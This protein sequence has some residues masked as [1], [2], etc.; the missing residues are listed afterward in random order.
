[1]L[2][3]L[4]L[5]D[6]YGTR[7]VR[8]GRGRHRRRASACCS[9]CRSSAS[10]TTA[11]T[12]RSRARRC[13]SSGCS[14]LPA[15][16]LTPSSTSCPT[17]SLFAIVG[18]PAAI[19]L[20]DRRSRWSARS[21]SRS[22]RTGCGAWARRSASIYIFFIGATGGALLAALLTDAFGPRA[23]VLVLVRPVDDHRRVPDPAR[24]VVHPQ[25][26]VAGR[27]GAA[28]RSW[29][30]TERQQ[31]IADGRSPRCRSPTSTSPTARCRCCSTSA[32]RCSKGEV[33]ALLGTN[34]AGKSTILRVIA[35]LGHAGT[36]R[37]P[38]QR[39][40][41]SPTSR[42]SSGRA[43]HPHAA[44]RQGRVPG[45]DGAREPRDGVR[46]S[47]AT[48]TPTATRRIDRVLELFPALAE[49]RTARRRRAVGR[50]A[51]DAGAGDGAAPRPRGA[52]HRRALARPRAARRAGAA[53]GRRAAQGRGH[54]DHHRRAVAQRRARRSPT[55]RCSS[56]RAR[57]ASRV[58]PPSSPNATTSPAP[59]SSGARAAD[60]RAR[61]AR[62][63]AARLRRRRHRARLSACS[64]W[65]SC[66]STGRPASSTSRSATWGSSAPACFA[67][68]VVE[69]RRA[70]SGS[71]PSAAL[72]VGTLFGALIELVVDPPAVR[73][74][75]RHRARRDH[76]HRAARRWRS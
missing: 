75:A 15:A 67:L 40:H 24:R 47:T 26:P 56:R 2:A 59:C 36:R 5:E 22:C 18:R 54:D 4:F 23:A 60:R 61:R 45:D 3:N 70:R 14:I 50:P 27:R 33:L 20:I 73:R 28:A 71:P 52:A 64:R 29:T 35:G 10:T 17:P 55:G 6:H 53:R 72:V 31:A 9:C 19:L 69:L 41:R 51:A 66:S 68:L 7:H 63:A 39:P 38:P 11:S 76:R 25:R 46:S 58:R 57:S 34:G 65:A 48:T 16:L 49:R 1:M 44:R 30:S 62:H 37:R 32:S 13:G 42:P 43:R 8:P 21:C 12:A 74:A